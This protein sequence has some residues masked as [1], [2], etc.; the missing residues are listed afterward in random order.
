MFTHREK[1]SDG[2]APC[3]PEEEIAMPSML[4]P[5]QDGHIDALID[6]LIAIARRILAEHGET[7]LQSSDHPPAA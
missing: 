5:E 2:R 1:C 3:S 6:V 7:V 4:E